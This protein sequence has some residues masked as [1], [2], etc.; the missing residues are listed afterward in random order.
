MKDKADDMQPTWWEWEGVQN[1][2]LKKDI[3][4]TGRPRHISEDNIKT[5]LES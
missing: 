4:L 2:G 3:I 1:F 5:M